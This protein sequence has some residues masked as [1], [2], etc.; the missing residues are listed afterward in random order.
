M[1]GKL[2]LA[3]ARPTPLEKLRCGWVKC[4]SDQD[5]HRDL[6]DHRLQDSG[7]ESFEGSDQGE[8]FIFGDH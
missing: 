4:G 1:S 8:S 3:F 7:V 6:N 5:Q 2:S